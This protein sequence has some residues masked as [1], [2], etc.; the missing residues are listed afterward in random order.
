[1]YNIDQHKRNSSE[2]KDKSKKRKRF[3][4]THQERLPSLHDLILP[5]PPL[6]PQNT[7]EHHYHHHISLPPPPTSTLHHYY[8]NT[9]EP[10]YKPN[11]AY[12]Y[13]LPTLPLF[14]PLES[15]QATDEQILDD[16]SLFFFGEKYCYYYYHQ[17]PPPS[18]L[19][20]PSTSSSSSCSSTYSHK[21]PKDFV[22]Y[23]PLDSS[24][25]QHHSTSKRKLIP[26]LNDYH[27]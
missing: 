5:S 13:Q 6:K 10:L 16:A 17:A 15:T 19:P 3:N 12:H 14:E 24:H 7:S 8:T 21:K 20:S 4:N 22:L 25:H 23:E 9:K 11:K 18:L 1:M 2:I 27:H 26:D